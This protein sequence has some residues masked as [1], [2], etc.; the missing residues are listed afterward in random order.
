MPSWPTQADYKDAL[1]N[2]DTAFRD[3]DL[4]QSTAER[5][6]MGVPR[7]RA[8]AFAAVYKMTG[9][10]GTVALKLFNFPNEDR[11]SRYKAVSDYLEQELGTKKPPCVVKFQ[12]HLEGIRVGKGWFPTLTMAWVKGVSLGEW[13]RQ[14]VE[15]KNPDVAA[16]KKMAELWAALVQQLQDNKIAHGDL[17]H[18]NVMVVNDAPVLVDYD[19]M[20]V[21]ALD[22]A[23]PSKKLDQLEFG[24]PAYQH[25]ARGAEKLGAHLDHFAAWVILV[26]L[27]AI[28]AD[29]QLYVKHVL[30]TDNENLL[31]SPHDMQTPDVSTLWPDLLRCKDPDVSGWARMIRESLDKPF[32]KIPPFTLDPFD[33]LR[34][35]VA[36]PTRDWVQ[37]EA[38]TNRLKQAGKSVPPELQIDPLDGLKKLCGAKIKDWSAI[39]AEGDR[40][41]GGGKT[42]AQDLRPVVDEARARVAARD[43]L[44]GA[45]DARDP[46]AIVA[47]YKPNLVNDWVDPTLVNGAKDAA[48]Q[49][50]L[51]DKLKAAAAA[52]GDG[53]ALIKL[54]DECS[55]KLSG[56]G[57]ARTYG[58]VADGFRT[59]A[60]AAEDFLRVF[61]QPTATER[62]VADAWQA[63]VAAGAPHPSLNNLHR[64]RGED[65]ARW[66]PLVEKLRRVPFAPS[67][68]NDTALV[69]AWG[70]G[71]ALA[72][73]REATEFATR[74][75]DAT[76]RLALVQAVERAIRAA[77]AGGPEDAVVGA[78]AKLPPGYAHPFATR[79]DEGSAAIK[80]LAEIQKVLA[81]D[82]PS[83][84]K[85]A[86][87]F[88]RLR[89][90]NPKLAK[91]LDKVNPTLWAEVEAALQRRKLLDTFALIDAEEARADRQDEK[92]MALWNKHGKLLQDRR[93]RE[94]LRERLT[95][96]RDRLSKWAKL[97]EALNARDMFTLRRRFNSYSDLLDGYPPLVE[98]TDEI[99]SLLVKADR[100]VA[101][102]EKLGVGGVLAADDLK[103]LRE[104]HDA[105][106]PE[107]K[108]EIERQVRARLA[109]DAR[110]VPAYPAYQVT[111]TRGG[112]VKACWAWGGHG[113]ITYCVVGVDGRKFLSS[114]DEADPYSRLTCKAEN[115]QR[116]GGGITLV[117][118]PGAAQAYVTIWPVVE[119]G[120]TV[121][122]GPPLTVGP[123][124]VSR[125]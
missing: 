79:V 96:A 105:F 117:P 18:D 30:K 40:L 17:Q 97:S 100:V 45:F 109:G 98:R 16:V 85:V 63:V 71:A 31:F 64:K 20:C 68:D 61:A 62:A 67:H 38:E 11:A 59:R 2:P 6:T 78:A 112:L 53:A 118:P 13:V 113:L 76:A 123:V 56:V 94:E 10:K 88:D 4:M 34:K 103:F 52:P 65:A 9:P 74:V 95:L 101:V 75:S 110:L 125:Y 58:Q 54:W 7:A 12:Y 39:L 50:A 48:G 122:H 90:K 121:V 1:Q 60:R 29:P 82:H 80:M 69:A 116:E 106:G 5:S 83:D 21:P 104:N 35:L 32:A 51:L 8:G 86:A 57:E 102:Q 36:A 14:T 114:P 92:W 99:R 46:R 43:A 89:A 72:G 41:T 108:K 66:A 91:R 33:R 28:A 25:P 93:D 3:P 26:A 37:I 49:V 27:R 23:D 124:P 111:G 22:P 44:K 70:T 19:G 15:K 87:A 107:V 24:K 120:W 55:A 115:H 77:D 47:V 119:L 42:I 84:R 73:C 81:Q